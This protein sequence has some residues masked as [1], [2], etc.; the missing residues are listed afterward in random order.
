MT[1]FKYLANYSGSYTLDNG[2]S[3][4]AFYVVAVKENNCKPLVMKC[5]QDVFNETSKLKE[6]CNVRPY[7]R[8]CC[9]IFHKYL[10]SMLIL[11]LFHMEH[12]QTIVKQL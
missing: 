6:R 11:F 4:V 3:G 9:G 5:S 1:K 8:K 12:E 2:K 7:R 10:P